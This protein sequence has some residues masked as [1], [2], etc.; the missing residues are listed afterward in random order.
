MPDQDSKLDFQ[1]KILMVN[2]MTG[3]VKE[4]DKAFWSEEAP[5]NDDNISYGVVVPSKVKSPVKYL[6]NSRDYNDSPSEIHRQIELANRMYLWEGIVGS[7]IDLMVD[8]SATDFS[9]E[10]IPEDSREYALC[11]HW[12]EEVNSKNNNMEKGALALAKE[13]L[14][15]YYISGNPFPFRVYSDVLASEITSPKV[16]GVKLE[17]PMEVY[18]INPL[19]VHIPRYTVLMGDKKMYLKF[20]DESLSLLASNFSDIEEQSDALISAGGLTPAQLKQLKEEKQILLPSDQITHIKR[21]SRGY[22]TWGAPFL[23]RAFGAMAIKKKIQALDEATIDGLIN[24]IVIFKV[25]DPKEFEATGRRSTWSRR[26]LAHFAA[27]I[28]SPNPSNYLVW[29]PDIDVLTVGPNDNLVNFDRRYEQADRDILKALGVP[30]VLLSG[31]GASAEKTE[32]VWVSVGSFMEKLDNARGQIGAYFEMILFEALK[33]NGMNTK[34]K[35]RIK[36]RKMSLRNEREIREFVTTWWDRGV[37]PTKSAVQ[38]LGQNWD[39]IV[40]LRKEENDKK[41]DKIFKRRDLPFS[42]PMGQP[43]SQVKNGRPP[44]SSN[45]ASPKPKS[46]TTKK[47]VKPLKRPIKSK[48]IYEEAIE[49]MLGVAFE[50]IDEFESKEDFASIAKSIAAMERVSDIVEDVCDVE[51]IDFE[52]HAKADFEAIRDEFFKEIGNRD[53]DE[54]KS[55]FSGKIITMITETIR[56]VNEPN[57][58]G[59]I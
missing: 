15:E 7:A 18:L 58:E 57:D 33:K 2:Q 11:Q 9:I 25:G 8:I 23:T 41:F 49:E 59:E 54:I 19:S 20:D 27:L 1:P 39:E 14:L 45:T 30:T 21:K 38:E 47:D 5:E 22:D 37:M 56:K 35:P 32:N 3:Q 46:K 36:W 44:K 34:A 52:T 4:V 31:E 16:R 53:L 12:K 29:T 10:N 13:L 51:D 43:A 6:E 17:L 28:S 55:D 24:N 50:T 48:A 40:R 42:G 26:R